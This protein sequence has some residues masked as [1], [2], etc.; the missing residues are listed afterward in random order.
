MAKFEKELQKIKYTKVRCKLKCITD[1][2]TYSAYRT[3]CITDRYTCIL[4]MYM[5]VYIDG[6]VCVH[7]LVYSDNAI[8]SLSPSHQLSRTKTHSTTVQRRTTKIQFTDSSHTINGALN[9]FS[10]PIFLIPTCIYLL[11]RVYFVVSSLL[12][13]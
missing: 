4:Y 10:L 13:N 12:L 2:T 5:Y 6:H 9:I 11:C 8:L 3:A 1:D 7:I